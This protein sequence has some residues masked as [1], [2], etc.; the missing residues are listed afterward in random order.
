MAEFQPVLKMKEPGWQRINHGVNASPFFLYHT[1]QTIWKINLH[2]AQKVFTVSVH[3]E[4]VK[5]RCECS[6]V[7]LSSSYLCCCGLKIQLL[8][9]VC[10]L[11]L[12]HLG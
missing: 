2:G 5:G 12:L 11:K 4:G 1:I 10:L 6:A 7:C 3:M 8:E 9:V